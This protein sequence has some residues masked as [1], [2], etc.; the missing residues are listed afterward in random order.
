MARC[1]TMDQSLLE[2]TKLDKVLPKLVKRGDDKIKS[3]GQ[4]ILDNAEQSSK[5]KPAES[6]L[7]QTVESKAGVSSTQGRASE[8]AASLKRQ[9]DAAPSTVVGVKKGSI[10]KPGS[11][12]S[13]KTGGSLTKASFP[14]KG[15]AKSSTSSTTNSIPAKVK[16]NHVVAK[17]SVFSSLQSA[18]KKP[19]T[20]IAAQKAAQ[21]ND[22][23]PR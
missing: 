12:V 21:Q 2:R 1:T 8:L 23:K 11:S 9:R 22:G 18:S 14:I 15:E 4:Q 16:V 19:G 17:P 3:L 13:T 5:Q 20:S 10:S 6:R 7:G